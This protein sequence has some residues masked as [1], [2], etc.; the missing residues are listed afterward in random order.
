M[1]HQ[2]VVEH[3]SGCY[4]ACCSCGGWHQ[5]PVALRVSLLREIL[6]LMQAGHGR[7]VHE[8]EAEDEDD[9]PV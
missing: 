7:H 9:I 5:G 8:A 2:L 1:E 3:S 6:S 4:Q